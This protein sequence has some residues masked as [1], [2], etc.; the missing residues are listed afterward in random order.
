MITVTPTPA[1]LDDLRNIPGKAELVAGRIVHHMP[2]GRIPGRIAKR[3]LRSLDDHETRTKLGEAVGDNVGYAIIP[4]LGNGRGSFSP[5][6]SYYIGPSPHDDAGFI[7]GPPT[8]AVEVRSEHDLGPAK[9]R[10]YEQKRADYF[11][12]G[13]VVVWDVDYRTETIAKYEP[14]DP[15]VPVVFSRGDAADAEPALPGWRLPVDEVF[16]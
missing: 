12:A 13:T 16:G 4:P 11:S 6:V 7:D 9:D 3:I 10:E 5:D 15:S 8:F 2:T 14:S 1:S